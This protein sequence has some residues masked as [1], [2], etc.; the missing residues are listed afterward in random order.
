VVFILAIGATVV[1]LTA[2]LDLSAASATAVAS[3]IRGMIINSGSSWILACLGA[4]GVACLMGFINGFLIEKAKIPFL[5]VTLGTL[6]IYASVVLLLTNGDTLSLFGVTN[7]TMID[8]LMNGTLGLFPT[9][10][11]I[12]ALLNAFAGAGLHLTPFGRSVY[13]VGSN[14]EAA[15]LAG[16]T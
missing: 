6:S 13:A 8:K 12:V 4:I 7:F 16:T 10:L 15:R 2:G 11:V 5:V 1:V 3:I 9:I 14:P